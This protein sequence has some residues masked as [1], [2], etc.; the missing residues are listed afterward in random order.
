MVVV[1]Q[2]YKAMSVI[3]AIPPHLAAERMDL[4]REGRGGRERLPE[5]IGGNMWLTFQNWNQLPGF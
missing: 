3:L 4:R 5:N 2:S 1:G